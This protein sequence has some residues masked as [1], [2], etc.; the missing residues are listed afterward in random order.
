MIPFLL[1]KLEQNNEKNR[2]GSLTILRHIINSCDEQMTNKKQIVIS[3]LRLLL[4]DT[5]NRVI[6]FTFFLNKKLN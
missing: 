6:F 4:N 1:Q 2:I 5:N 3:G